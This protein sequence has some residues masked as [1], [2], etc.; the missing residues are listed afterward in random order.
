M[1]K[2]E[3]QIINSCVSC[4][5]ASDGTGSGPYVPLG[6]S[7]VADR[8]ACHARYTRE[9]WPISIPSPKNQKAPPKRCPLRKA[10]RLVVL[11]T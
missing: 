7:F 11:E 10:P 1:K 6:A 3:T 9:G 2:P 4:P 5:F 8:W